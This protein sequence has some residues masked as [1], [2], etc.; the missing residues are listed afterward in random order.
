VISVPALA[1]DTMLELFQHSDG[2]SDGANIVATAALTKLQSLSGCL[3]PPLQRWNVSSE[4]CQQPAFHTD[5][6][7]TESE[8]LSPKQG[9]FLISPDLS[10]AEVLR[11]E[12]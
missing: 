4:S 7:T 5:T 8:N 2:W 6:F 1:P 9:K 10:L 12:G 11:A 3:T